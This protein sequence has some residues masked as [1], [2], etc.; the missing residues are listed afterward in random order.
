MLL[1]LTFLLFIVYSKQCLYLHKSPTRWS[2]N[3]SP[4]K[5]KF[6]KKI[7]LFISIMYYLCQSPNKLFPI[8][9][10]PGSERGLSILFSATVFS[11]VC[12]INFMLLFCF[13]CLSSL[14]WWRLF[15]GFVAYG[16]GASHL[17][18]YTLY[19]FM[20]ITLF[21][22]FFHVYFLQNWKEM[23]ELFRYLLKPKILVYLNTKFK[24]AF[25]KKG[26]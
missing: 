13:I 24:S 9:V 8:W 26:I 6:M 23:F 4:L 1:F 2:V 20:S 17:C 14:V 12:G 22:L 21:F 3:D 11:V 16:F 18:F 5:L 25:V 7:L 19:F 15:H 10:W